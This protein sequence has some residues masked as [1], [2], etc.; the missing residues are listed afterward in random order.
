MRTV[1]ER[2]EQ[3]IDRRRLLDGVRRLGA[4]VSGGSDSTAL[5]YLLADVCDRR[6]VE[7]RAFH[8][9]HQLRGADSDADEACVR[10]TARKLRIELE[11]R[12]ADVALLAT[13][14]NWNLEDAGRRARYA[15][16]EE[17]LSDGTVD[18]V[19]TGHH[20]NDQ[21]ET[22]LFRILRGGGSTALRGVR[23]S[24]RP[25]IIRPLID[26][27]RAEIRQYLMERSIRWRDD[28][29]NEDPRFARNRIRTELLP[30]LERDWNPRLTEALARNAE[31]AADEED[32]WEAECARLAL[33]LGHFEGEAWLLKA[34]RLADLHPAVERRVWRYV[35]GELRGGLQGLDA[36]HVERLRGLA[37]K[38]GGSGL[39]ELPGVTVERS[40]DMIRLA[41][42]DHVAPLPAS[43]PTAVELP[44]ELDSPDGLSSIRLRRLS[45]QPEIESYTNRYCSGLAWDRIPGQVCLRAWRPGDRFRANAGR[46]DRKVKNLFQRARVAAW[47]RA[48][49]PVLAAAAGGGNELVWMRGFGVAGGFAARGGEPSV[50]SVE[51][52]DGQGR[53]ISGIED[54][55]KNVST[56]RGLR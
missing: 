40:F 26:V 10:E 19:A 4:A 8:L 34:A 13:E 24:R 20:K 2:V 23:A 39:L 22:V 9:N 48:G 53:E 43:G 45:L 32:F 52:F 6:G 30:S 16:F 14:N 21:A 49:W 28:A 5:L 56:R 15:F 33:S 31:L 7:L 47:D 41:V 54:W 1:R 42:R 29:S 11:V 37:G 38:T 55:L 50:V 27:D 18:A 25:G 12:S 44:A 3:T 46:G 17:R 35:L 51:E 36:G